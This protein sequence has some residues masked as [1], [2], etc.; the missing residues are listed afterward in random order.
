MLS[1][2]I[3]STVTGHQSSEKSTYSVQFKKCFSDYALG[4]LYEGVTVTGQLPS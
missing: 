2:Y 1:S 3:A 4:V